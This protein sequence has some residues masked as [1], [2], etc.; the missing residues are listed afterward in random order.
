MDCYKFILYKALWK[1]WNVHC[2]RRNAFFFL[3]K[4]FLIEWICYVFINSSSYLNEWF[5]IVVVFFFVGQY[6]KNDLMRQFDNQVNDFMDSLIEES[7]TLEP[8]PLPAV[9]SPPLSDK[10]RIKLRCCHSTHPRSGFFFLLSGKNDWC[11]CLFVQAFSTS[12]RPRQAVCQ[13]QV[14]PGVSQLVHLKEQLLPFS[15]QKILS[16]MLDLRHQKF[17]PPAAAVSSSELFEVNHIR[18]IYHMFIA[19][20]ILFILSTLVVDFIDEGRWAK[21][22]MTVYEIKRFLPFTLSSLNT[23]RFSKSLVCFVFPPSSQAGAGLR[24]A[25]LCVWTDSSGSVHVDLHVPLCVGGSLQFVPAV[26][27]DPVRELQPLRVVQFPLC[28]HLP[29][30]PGVWSG[31]PA[32]VY[33]GEQRSATC[34]ALHRHH[35]TGLWPH[36]HKNPFFISENILDV[37][38]HS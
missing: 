4:I 25:G 38:L 16:K 30:L 32:C 9:F 29:A 1:L 35:G 22:K 20:L 13:S 14:P 23:V 37:S 2:S 7:A 17:S 33:S 11:H 18:T 10:E 27:T 28:L 26:V 8:A 24:P 5:C 31:I 15:L 36:Y 19:L 3:L 34:F 21:A 6:L 12:S